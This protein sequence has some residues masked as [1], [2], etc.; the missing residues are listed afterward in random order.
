MNLIERQK[1]SR[2][3][4][5]P[6]EF[7]LT[8]SQEVFVIQDRRRLPDRRSEKYDLD[9]LDGKV[10]YLKTA[11]YENSLQPALNKHDSVVIPRILN[12][13]S[14]DELTFLLECHGNKNISGSSKLE[15]FFKIDKFSSYGERAIGLMNLGLLS[16]CATE[17]NG[18]DV[19]A[20]H[21]TY[22][23]DRLVKL[24]ASQNT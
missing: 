12:Q 14:I 9:D 18:S 2:R 7:P 20:Y 11:V 13:I 19:G 16:R 4:D 21:F 10:Y 24:F 6:V 22:L 15:S 8:D 1:V 5:L 3:F 23:A 17:G